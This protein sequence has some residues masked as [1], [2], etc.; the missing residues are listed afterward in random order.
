MGEFDQAFHELNLMEDCIDVMFLWRF[1]PDQYTLCALFVV[2]SY[3]KSAIA[4]FMI[5]MMS[6]L[7]SNFFSSWKTVL[8]H[9]FRCDW[10]CWVYFS[11]S[12]ISLE[13][14]FQQ[15]HARWMHLFVIIGLLV[16]KRDHGP[17]NYVHLP[18][19]RTIFQWISY[20]WISFLM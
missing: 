20:S 16:L 10:V 6:S 3:A 12:F 1:S 14:C 8:M 2:E 11:F 4:S 18:K 9:G 17:C 13:F 7:L 15:L 5:C 19:G